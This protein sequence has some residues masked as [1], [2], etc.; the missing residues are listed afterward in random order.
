MMSILIEQL[1]NIT[2]A[3]FLGHVGEIELGA[4]ALAGI[5]YLAVYMLGFGFSLGLQVVIAR[6]NG[7]QHYSETGKTFFQGLFFLS[8]LAVLLCLFSKLFSPIILSRLIASAEVYH[9]VIDYLDGRIWGLLFSFPFLA[10]RSFLVGITRT[11]ALNVAALTAVLVNISGNC[12]FIFHWNMGITGAAI[13]S[14]FAEACSLAVLTIHVLRKMDRRLYG[15]FWSFDKGVLLHVCRVSVWSMFHSLLAF[16]VAVEHLGEMELA[17]TNVIRS[18]STVFFVIVN[19]F[20]ATTGSLVSNL[21]GAGQKAQVIPLCNRVVRLGYAIGFPLV[22]L[23][24]IFY[25]P[26]IGI[27]TGSTVLMQIAHLPF[28]VMLLNYVFSLPGYIYMNAVT[29]TGATRM[30][31]IF[32]LITI[33]AYQIYLWSISGFSTSLSVYW[34]AEYLYVILLGLLSVIYFKYKHY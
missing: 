22:I 19:S 34:T 21:L 12:L 3:I 15:L 18:V 5:W 6:R 25:R 1:I 30:T 17:A 8:G 23:A 26:I 14:S 32:Q 11:K 29:G 28:V 4:S 10:L 16:F 2:D 24:V 9:A 7:E 31:F 20:A 27:Y 33:V 13:A